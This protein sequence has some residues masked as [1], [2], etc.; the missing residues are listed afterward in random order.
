MSSFAKINKYWWVAAFIVILAAFLVLPLATGREGKQGAVEETAAVVDL[1]FDETVDVT[2]EFLAEPFAN[3][4][5]KT[6]GVVE[7]VYVKQG[8]KVKAGDI[9]LTLQPESTSSTLAL[10]QSE[11]ISAQDDLEDIE[12]I[13]TE[14]AEKIIE[15]KEATE[16]YDKAVAYLK[17]LQT[18]KRV[19][20]TER[21]YSLEHTD[22]GY[23]YDYKTKYYREPAT[24]DMLIDAENNL[25]LERAEMEE[26][27]LEVDRLQNLEDD[28]VA[29][30]ARI[31]SAQAKVESLSIIAPFDGEVL[32]MEHMVGDV[33]E[34]GELSVYMANI[35]NLYAVSELD[36]S[37][38]AQIKVG[39][40]VTV[41]LDALGDM[42][43]TGKVASISPVGEYSSGVVQYTVR[44]DVKKP[45]GV[46]FLPLNST[47]NLSILVTG[48]AQALAVPIV[49]IQN[50]STGEYVWVVRDEVP[51][52]VDVVG[53]KIIDD[54]VVVTGNLTAGELVQT[55]RES[56][57]NMPALFGAGD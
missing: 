16:N 52:R 55:T 42:A 3:L 24:D 9:L 29:A 47:A 19:P 49:A 33:V 11:L 5:W 25:E 14:L 40:A 32:Y 46:A 23:V 48:D 13:D 1:N 22:F 15:L 20:R 50:D 39:N 44:V 21:I 57:Q 30:E 8:E 7:A 37:D 56:T 6:S 36:E 35:N 10:G 31:A 53:G 4:T 18:N 12:T 17:Y 26:L 54:L 34:K 41:T 51:V 27:Q 2:G 45:E 38:I 43:F 28:I